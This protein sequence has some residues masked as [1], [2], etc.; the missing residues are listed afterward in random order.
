MGTSLPLAG[1]L[2]QRS[3]DT[4]LRSR[5]IPLG[6]SDLS[7][8]DLVELPAVGSL[9]STTHRHGSR[10][11]VTVRG[12]DSV[13]SLVVLASAQVLAEV[14]DAVLETIDTGFLHVQNPRR[15]PSASSDPT[16]TAS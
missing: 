12:D 15:G 3:C 8:T 2:G 11:L 10:P 9:R 1:L 13:S 16:A 6:S 7:T 14:D 4:M 5:L